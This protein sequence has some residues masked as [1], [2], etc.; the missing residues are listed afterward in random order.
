MITPPVPSAFHSSVPLLPGF[1]MTASTRYDDIADLLARRIAQAPIKSAIASRRFASCVANRAS[2]SPPHRAPMR[3]WK[4]WDSPPHAPA[5]V[6]MCCRAPGLGICRRYPVPPSGL[7][8]SHNG[9]R[10]WPWSAPHRAPISLG[11]WGPE[12]PPWTPRPS[13]RS[14]V[15]YPVCTVIRTLVTSATTAWPATRR[16]VSRWRAWPRHPAA[17][18]IPTTWSS[19]PVARKPWPS[20]CACSLPPATW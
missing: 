6:I 17:C 14:V 1:A 4:K 12:R 11:A 5:P 7:S 8:R 9:I 19:P 18:C 20:R 2:V 3:D 10:C 13:N 16:C 15:C